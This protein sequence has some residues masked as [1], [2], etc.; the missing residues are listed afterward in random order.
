[1][2][3]KARILEFL[4]KNRERYNVNQIARLVG[5]SVGSAFKILKRLE[6]EN[7]ANASKKD[8]EIL[9]ELKSNDKVRSEYSKIEQEK[10][11]KNRK[12]TKSTEK[13]PKSHFLTQTETQQN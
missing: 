6:K 13:P 11:S 7:Y 12:K 1:M 9:Y 10:N 8:N 3:N 5:I 2:K 4:Y